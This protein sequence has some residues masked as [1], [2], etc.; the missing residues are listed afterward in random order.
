MNSV[1]REDAHPGRLLSSGNANSR[2]GQKDSESSARLLFLHTWVQAQRLLVRWCHDIQTV[3]QA[4][5]LPPMFLVSMNLVF[6]KPVSSVS[7]HSA[8]YGSVPMAALVGAIF[9]S[10]ASGICLMRERDEGLLARLWVLPVNRG[11]G[12]LARL[13]AEAARILVTTV[14][15]MCT[16]VALG[17]RY[18]QGIPAALVWVTV[19]VAF[20]VA[21]SFLVITMALYLV[22][23]VLVEATGIAVTLLIY[24]CTGFVP[25]AEY[26][27]WIQPVV[28]HQPLSQAVDAMRGLSLGGPVLAPTIA[29][30][31]WSVGIVAV[32][33]V[34]M[35]IG[36]RKASTR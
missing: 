15:V 31:F 28:H 20:G 23:T 3:I 29:T 32:S 4:L 33:A 10:T 14:L 7:G 5:I 36:Y 8:L 25:L 16:G 1:V 27:N 30:L 17:F 9:G 12:L 35:A 21:F 13:V 24:F 18:E 19:P 34:P 26:P 6:G 11:S 2:A 22:N